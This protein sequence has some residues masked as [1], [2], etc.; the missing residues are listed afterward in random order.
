MN[1][2]RCNRCVMDNGSDS[3][4]QFDDNGNCNYCNQAL[5][6]INTTYF[7]RESG[8]AKLN[9]M[10][11]EI[12][13]EG[14]NKPYDCAMGISG[15]LDSCYLAYLGY[16]WGL[17]ILAFHVD[18]GF[19]TEV[20]KENIN[21]LVKRTNITMVTIRPNEEQYNAITKGFF[22]TEGNYQFEVLRGIADERREVS[23]D[24]LGRF[25]K[26]V[27]ISLFQVGMFYIYIILIVIYLLAINKQKVLIP[28][29]ATGIMVMQ[30]IFLY[31]N[32]ADSSSWIGVVVFFR[33]A[34][35]YFGE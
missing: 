12:K 34:Y 25:F 15:G 24:T 1:I 32:Y 30:Y 18:D 27:P 7:P 26:A 35:C 16:K 10:L 17:R 6:E 31:I 8:K 33:Y 4:I 21:R 2:K 19:D 9:E 23:W 20:S 13:E 5:S 22:V 28:A 3:K 29:I 11:E 14:K